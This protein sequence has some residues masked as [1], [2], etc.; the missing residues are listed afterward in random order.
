MSASAGLLTWLDD[1][2]PLPPARLALGPDSDAP[3]LVS[4]GGRLDVPRLE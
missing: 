1:D 3:G 2:A 4:A